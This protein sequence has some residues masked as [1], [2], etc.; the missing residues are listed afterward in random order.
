MSLDDRIL[1][2]RSKHAD[3]DREIDREQHRAAPDDMTI[4]K[5]KLEKLRV[6][7]EI[8]RLHPH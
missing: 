1:S 3:L 2:L 5:L 6:K 8:D 7:E 4:K